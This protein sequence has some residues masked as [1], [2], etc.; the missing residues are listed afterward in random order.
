M[1]TVHTLP[2]SAASVA[3]SRYAELAREL[4][5]NPRLIEDETHMA[6]RKAA[7]RRFVAAFEGATR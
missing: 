4:R 6:R 2:Q 3:W 1:G 5:N 7:Y